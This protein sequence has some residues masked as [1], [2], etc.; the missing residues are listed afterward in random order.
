MRGSV[1]AL[2]ASLV[3]AGCSSSTGTSAPVSTAEANTSPT[4]AST[5]AATTATSPPVVGP[6][7]TVGPGTY[8]VGTGNGQIAP[9]KYFAPA[10]SSG[11][12]CYYARLRNND[13]ET[14]D[15]IAEELSHGQIIMTVRASDGYVKVSGCTFIAAS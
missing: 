13:G 7:T 2:A 11:P 3:I 14:A 1:L 10:L 8:E 15:I 9:G 4:T 5:S 12:P 6:L